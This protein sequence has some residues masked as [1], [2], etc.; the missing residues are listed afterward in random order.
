VVEVAS[1]DNVMTIDLAQAEQAILEI[2]P[3]LLF[4][5]PAATGA[6]YEAPAEETE[7]LQEPGPCD[8]E[9]GELS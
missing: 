9:E 3:D 1:A 4:S 5:K 2:D 8:Q 6:P 7:V